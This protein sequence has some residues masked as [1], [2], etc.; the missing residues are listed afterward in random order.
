VGTCGTDHRY[1]LYLDKNA[2][3]AAAITSCT[4]I[5]TTSCTLAGDL[6]KGTA[7]YWRVLASRGADSGWSLVRSLTTRGATEIEACWGNGG[8]NGRCYDCNG[9]GYIN[10][11]DFSCFAKRWL[12]TVMP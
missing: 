9:D 12:E 8:G 1:T 10:I 5:A 2:S 6:D 11:L 4:K 3:P 7:Y